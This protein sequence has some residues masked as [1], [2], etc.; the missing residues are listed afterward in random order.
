[1]GGIYLD[2]Q[3]RLVLVSREVAEVF[4][5]SPRQRKRGREALGTDWMPARVV[6][7]YEDHAVAQV[8]MGGSAGF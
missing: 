4:G 2:E 5:A 1:V 6:S 8:R 3:N 7:T